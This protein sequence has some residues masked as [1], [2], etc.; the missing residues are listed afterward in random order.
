[1][2]DPFDFSSSRGSGTDIKFVIR[3]SGTLTLGRTES[4]R[5]WELQPYPV[6]ESLE[7]REV[8]TPERRGSGHSGLNV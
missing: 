6:E 5:R 3:S 8:L 7:A 1:M 4:L 2:A